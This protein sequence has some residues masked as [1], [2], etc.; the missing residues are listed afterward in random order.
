M[1][2]TI[3]KSAARTNAVKVSAPVTCETPPRKGSKRAIAL[4][5]VSALAYAEDN[6]RTASLANMRTY[7]GTSPSEADVK[8]GKRR[9]V[10]GRV[11]N[12]LP[13]SELPKGKTSAE[14]RI[15]FAEEL[16]T[17]RAA[18]PK[19]GTKAKALRKGQTGRRTNVQQRIVRAAEEA[20]SVFFAELG[21]S[22]AKPTAQRDA[23]KRTRGASASQVAAKDAAKPTH[24]EL[25]QP[26]APVS[27]DD[28]VQHMQTQ[29]A[30]LLAY[31]NKHA[32]KRPTT[33]GQFAELL[34]KLKI[35]A[36]EAANA[37]QLRKAK[38]E[39]DAAA[40]AK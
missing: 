28:Y 13:V 29:L 38:A 19:E 21:H 16:V 24:S 20:C 25:V 14:D 4:A 15:A 5:S 40:K 17:L 30:A 39:A 7:L 36:N 1:T 37:Y 8:I 35:V 11:A 10:I 31:D 12:R 2:K 34:G 32:K 9:W 26:A 23:D 22:N 27:S 18:P 3:A 6:S 33:H